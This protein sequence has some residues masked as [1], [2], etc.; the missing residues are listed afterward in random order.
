MKQKISSLKSFNSSLKF[1]SLKVVWLED[2]E[3]SFRETLQF[4]IC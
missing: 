3:I 2:V 4:Y 1:P